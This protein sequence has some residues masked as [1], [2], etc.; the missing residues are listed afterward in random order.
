MPLPTPP[1]ANAGRLYYMDAARGTM[2]LLGVFFH[3]ALFYSPENH[4][5]VVQGN[6]TRASFYYLHELIFSFRMPVFFMISGYFCPLVLEKFGANDFLANKA[7]RIGVPLISAAV[8]INTAQSYLLH[9]QRHGHLPIGDYLGSAAYWETWTN[10]EWVWHLWFLVNLLVYFLVAYLFARLAGLG[11]ADRVTTGLTGF[12]ATRGLPQVGLILPLPLCNLTID[13]AAYLLPWTQERVPLG[14]ISLHTVLQYVPYFVFG[15]I[16]YYR[17]SLFRRFTGLHWLSVLIWACAFAAYVHLPDRPDELP[18]LVLRRYVAF[19]LAWLGASIVL[20][21]FQVLIKSSSRLATVGVDASY[22]TYLFHHLLVL[23][24]GLGFMRLVW[25]PYLEYVL[26][27]TI[28]TVA[29]LFIHYVLVARSRW[30]S[31]MFNGTGPRKPPV[32]QGPCV[33]SSS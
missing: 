9:V 10:G 16:C 22:T 23:A 12:R 21:L 30:L 8:L 1:A 19:V 31:M 15:A 11:F 29:T 27:V 4:Q 2:M 5:W 7:R 6:D 28:T 24:L 33:S 32:N 17:E 13:A 3:A 14:I 26:M 25:N 18:M 20:R